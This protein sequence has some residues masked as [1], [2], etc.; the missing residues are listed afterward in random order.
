MF[1][2]GAERHLNNRLSAHIAACLRRGNV[3]DS[4][5]A[6]SRN[7]ASSS[8]DRGDSAATPAW[9]C[10]ANASSAIPTR[11]F[12][13]GHSVENRI[14]L[15]SLLPCPRRDE[16]RRRARQCHDRGRGRLL[17]RL[18]AGRGHRPQATGTRMEYRA[19]QSTERLLTLFAEQGHQGHV[20]RARLGDEEEPAAHPQDPRR[21]PRSGLPRTDARAGVPAD[22]RSVSRRD[23]RSKA[24]AR[25]HHRRAGA[26]L[27][28]GQLLASRASRCGPSTSSAISVSATTRASSRSRT[29]G[30]AF[31]APPRGPAS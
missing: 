20:L 29:I 7:C 22:A 31:R 11:I 9:N 13:G 21:R 12:G 28:R 27:S 5:T 4:T 25:G 3:R 16:R 6:R 15:T 30:T 8:A 2:A 17:P 14:F 10:G 24:H 18:G 1:Q 23:A 19:E 26:G